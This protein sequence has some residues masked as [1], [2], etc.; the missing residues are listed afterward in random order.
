VRELVGEVGRRDAR[1]HVQLGKTDAARIERLQVEAVGVG[2]RGP[3]P[4][5]GREV[6][7]GEEPAAPARAAVGVEA[8]VEGAV[9]P[10]DRR[11]EVPVVEPLPGQAE[12]RPGDRF[13]GAVRRDQEQVVR[14]RFAERGGERPP[15]GLDLLGR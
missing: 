15:L 11:E 8:V 7:L 13:A 4:R 14:E 5:A 10:A 12:R 9:R 3:T 1:L 6:V 2:E